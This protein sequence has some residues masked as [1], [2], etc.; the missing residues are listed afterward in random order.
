MTDWHAWHR[1]YDDRASSLARRLLIVRRRVDELVRSAPPV[2]R[3]LS[4]YAG[5]GRD[6]I[7]VLETLP[8]SGR[9]QLTLV[10]LDAELAEEAR[11]RAIE[12][13]VAAE[14]VSG[15]AGLHATWRHV[16]PVDLLMLCGVFGNV[17]EADVRRTIR[18]V[19]ALLTEAGTVLWTRG[20]VRGTDVRPQIR[21][22]FRAAGMEELA[23][24]AEPIGYGVGVN[25]KTAGAPVGEVPDRLFSFVR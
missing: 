7:P 14:V 9:P 15:D 22:W 18:A 23:F 25:R 21:A 5:D 11:W 17:S 24:D 1:D 20:H 12:A 19:P 10:E 13:D 8:P 2:R 3:V 16:P 6:V 4:L